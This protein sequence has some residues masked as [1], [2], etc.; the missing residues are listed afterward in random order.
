MDMARLVQ[1][2]L[3]C[4]LVSVCSIPAYATSLPARG[5][6]NYGSSLLPGQI[7]IAPQ[8]VGD[9][10]EMVV[11]GTPSFDENDGTCSGYTLEV[12][13]DA[14]PGTT[15]TID[16]S[17]S[18]FDPSDDNYSGFFCDLSNGMLCPTSAAQVPESGFTFPP[19]LSGGIYSFNFTVPAAANGT[20]AIVIDENAAGLT[21]SPAV[22]PEPN[23]LLLLASGL[24]SILAIR[25]RS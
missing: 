22:T 15:V 6:S 20:T 3:I 25:F 9:L 11:C 10:T 5:S 1:L 12:V 19:V 21:E 18:F 8:S 2:T 16:L 7:P 4:A 23:S 17:S 13:T 14:T 24:F